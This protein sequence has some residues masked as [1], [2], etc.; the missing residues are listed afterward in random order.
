[1]GAKQHIPEDE[2]DNDLVQKLLTELSGIFNWAL[3]G[4]LQWQREGL[5]PPDEVKAATEGYRTEMDVIREWMGERCVT[6]PDKK[7]GATQL[8]ED[9]QQWAETNAGWVMKQRKFGQKMTE[10]GFR[11]ERTPR[12]EYRGIGLVADEYKGQEMF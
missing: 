7:V 10:H 3:E 9:Y 5:N 11:R 12:V 1:M 8:Y 4:C 2:R 6:G